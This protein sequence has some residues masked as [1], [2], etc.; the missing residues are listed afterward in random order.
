MIDEKT[1]QILNNEGV[2]LSKSLPKFYG[3]VIFNFFDGNYV[4]TNVEQSIKKDNLNQRSKNG[5]NRN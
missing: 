2:R 5:V 1:K 3:K 4:N